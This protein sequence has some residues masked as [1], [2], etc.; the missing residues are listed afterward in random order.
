MIAKGFIGAGV[1]IRQAG[2]QRPALGEI[3]ILKT[4]LPISTKFGV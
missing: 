2:W 3:Y 4:T 1:K